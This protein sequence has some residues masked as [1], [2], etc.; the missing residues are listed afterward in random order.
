M[1]YFLTQ[2]LKGQSGDVNPVVKDVES[3]YNYYIDKGK[4]IDFTKAETQ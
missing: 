4:E 2:L 3:V 1:G